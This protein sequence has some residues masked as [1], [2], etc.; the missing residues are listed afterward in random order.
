[1]SSTSS[2]L[3]GSSKSLQSVSVDIVCSPKRTK[4]LSKKNFWR[5]GQFSMLSRMTYTSCLFVWMQCAAVR[6]TFDDINE[7][8]HWNVRSFCNGTL[9]PRSV[10][11]GNC[12]RLAIWPLTILFAFELPHLSWLINAAFLCGACGTRIS[13][14]PLGL[15]TSGLGCK[16]LQQNLS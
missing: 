1:M 12:L 9:Y 3:F 5:L 4:T 13:V 7:P 15:R 2:Q 16:V 8:P 6:T 11:Q 10:I 14:K